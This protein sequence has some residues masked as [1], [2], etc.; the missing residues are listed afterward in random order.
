MRRYHIRKHYILLVAAAY[1]FAISISAQDFGGTVSAAMDA[2]REVRTQN[3]AS[4]EVKAIFAKAIDA[5][6]D[7]NINFC[8]FYTGMSKSD[9]QTLADFYKL[10]PGEWSAQAL[11][12]S[13][14]VYE[15][16]FSLRSVRKLTKGGN[17]F[18]E[19]AQAVANR[20]GTLEKEDEST[21]SLWWTYCTIDDV[22][23]RFAERTVAEKDTVFFSHRGVR[24]GLTLFDKKYQ[25]RVEREQA[26]RKR[27]EAERVE[28]Q[29]AQKSKDAITELAGNM[30]EIPGKG[31][32]ICK[33]EATQALWQSVMGENPSKF[34]SPDRPVES[35]SFSQ[36]EEFLGKLNALPEVKNSGC[37]YRLPSIGEWEYACRAGGS[38]EF[39]RLANGTEIGEYTVSEVAWCGRESWEGGSTHSVG[40]KMPNAFG[41]YDMLGNVW[42]W[43]TGGKSGECTIRGGA[44]DQHR[45]ECT[46]TIPSYLSIDCGIHSV[47][48]D[49][50]FRLAADRID[51]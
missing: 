18:D 29:I 40:Q 43:V 28:T 35:I 6:E 41:L 42:E 47:A 34:K 13:M 49:L 7:G 10:K 1:S 27:Q 45:S 30:V 12:S 17:S 36:I 9:A 48:D 51:Q 11:S 38:G 37:Q 33:Y 20:I 4:A 50:G 44:Y 8:G 22:E 16:W 31:F 21:E 26:E 2:F 15:L 23:A 14:A 39:C 3:A 5:E 32:A 25:R 19:L 24:E 46:A